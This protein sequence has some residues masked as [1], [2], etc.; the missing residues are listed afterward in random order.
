[1]GHSTKMIFLTF[2]LLFQRFSTFPTTTTATTITTEDLLN[3]SAGR[4]PIDE[5]SSDSSTLQK[6]ASSEEPGK[7]TD[8]SDMLKLI[9]IQSFRINDPVFYFLLSREEVTVKNIYKMAL[10]TEMMSYKKRIYQNGMKEVNGKP[11]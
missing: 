3:R 2:T 7:A 6:A 10:F 1:M 11:T 8:R 5:I 4:L 9:L